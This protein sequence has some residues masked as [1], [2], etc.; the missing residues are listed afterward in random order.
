MAKQIPFAA[1]AVKTDKLVKIMEQ[2]EALKQ[3]FAEVVDEIEAD[4]AKA[5]V[6]DTVAEALAAVDDAIDGIQD[7]LE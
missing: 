3:E 4:G 7:V 5:S 6:V 2:L 1:K